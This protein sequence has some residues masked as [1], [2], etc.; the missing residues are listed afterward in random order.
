[1][2][3]YIKVDFKGGGGYNTRACMH[4]VTVARN[5]KVTPDFQ[6]IVRHGEYGFGI[7]MILLR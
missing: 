1:M 2:F 4:D 6:I 3:Y 7:I 5:I